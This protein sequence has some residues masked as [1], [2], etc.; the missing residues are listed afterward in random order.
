M[1]TLNTG[2]D[3]LQSDFHRRVAGILGSLAKMKTELNE[4]NFLKWIVHV[5]CELTYERKKKII[6]T[7]EQWAKCKALKIQLTSPKKK[8]KLEYQVIISS[9]VLMPGM[10]N[11]TGYSGLECMVASIPCLVPE[12]SDVW[13][14]MRSED[15]LNTTFL[16][17]P[18]GFSDNAEDDWKRKI[19]DVLINNVDACRHARD[20]SMKLKSSALYESS[21]TLLPKI[22]YGMIFK[23]FNSVKYIHLNVSFSVN[24][25]FHFYK[26]F[27]R[28]NKPI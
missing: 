13:E 10:F 22:L 12:N 6:S 20:L 19:H 28:M 4:P 11:V 17:P 25:R 16:V 23:F 2:C 8:S 7:L 9:L 27:Q 24:Y 21:K 5:E 18:L 3:I 1:L 26:K 15:K 14:V